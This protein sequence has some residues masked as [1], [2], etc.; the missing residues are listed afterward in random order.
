MG[1]TDCVSFP[2]VIDISLTRSFHNTLFGRKLQSVGPI[3]YSSS[4]S[5]S[6]PLTRIVV[7]PSCFLSLVVVTEPD[8]ALQFILEVDK[9]AYGGTFHDY[10]E[11]V[12]QFG[13]VNLFSV[14]RVRLSL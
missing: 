2:S 11:A 1:P 7:N 4:Y 8:E 9:E 10:A 14:V 6:L 5:F 12:V 3:A 13:Y